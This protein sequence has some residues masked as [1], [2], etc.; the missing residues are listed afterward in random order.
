MTFNKQVQNSLNFNSS[1]SPLWGFFNLNFLF[2]FY[3]AGFIFSLVPP[4]VDFPV[5]TLPP[6]SFLKASKQ[7][8]KHPSQVLPVLTRRVWSQDPEQNAVPSGDTRKVLTRF[9]CPNRIDTRDPFST[10]QTLMV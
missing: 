9:S 1:S 6:P 10:S 3:T 2:M 4:R 8:S 5:I 7:T